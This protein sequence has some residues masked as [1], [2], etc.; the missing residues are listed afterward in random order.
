MSA[1]LVIAIVLCVGWG[2]VGWLLRG[3]VEHTAALMKRLEELE[4][5][6]EPR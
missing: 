3:N 4:R 2:I 6:H 5:K 1:L